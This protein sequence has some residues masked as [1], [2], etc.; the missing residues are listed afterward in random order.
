M[1]HLTA[2]ET[3]DLKLVYRTL[4]ARLLETPDLM[5]SAFFS[6]LQTWLQTLAQVDKVDISDHAAWEGWL[7]NPA[8]GCKR[9]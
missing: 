1:S 3:S 6:E 9:P 2:F 8:V 5:D 4:H 7:G